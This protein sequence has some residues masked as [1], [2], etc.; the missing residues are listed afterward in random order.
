LISGGRPDGGG[1]VCMTLAIVSIS[2]PP[3]ASIQQDHDHL[4]L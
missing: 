3:A 2:H 1:I 4:T